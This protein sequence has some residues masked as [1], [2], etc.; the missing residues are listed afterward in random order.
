MGEGMLALS[1]IVAFALLGV[2]WIAAVLHEHG[3]TPMRKLSALMK[4][5]ALEVALVALVSIGMIHHGATK[6]NVNCKMENVKLGDA[7]MIVPD[8]TETGI[9]HF[10]LYTLHSHTNSDWLAFGGYEDWF[11]LDGGG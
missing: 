2:L 9:L 5:P 10:T 4:R 11:Y 8:S 1:A 3:L 6:T 7:P